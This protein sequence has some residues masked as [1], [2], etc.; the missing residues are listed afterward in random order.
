MR[1]QPGMARSTGAPAPS[2]PPNRIARPGRWAMACA[3]LSAAIAFCGA[4]AQ[5]AP[6]SATPQ[7]FRIERADPALD[8]LIAPDAT[9]RT[10][11]SGFGFADGPVWVRGHGGVPGHLLVSS[12]IGNVVYKVSPA[13]EVSVA[14]DTA[15]YSGSDFAHDGKLASFARLHLILIGPNCT[16]IDHQGRLIWCAGQDRALKRLEPDGTRT[17]LA[18]KADGKRFNGPNDV[19]I[20]ANGAI[21]FTDSDVGL[22]GGINGGL[23]QMPNAVWMWKDGKVTQVVSRDELGSE[24]NGIALSPDDKYLYL[25]AGTMSA[26]PKIMRY[27][28]KADGSVG[29]GTLFTQGP[30][31]GDGMK[32]DAKGNLY[33]TGPMPG[34][35]RIT[36]PTGKLLGLLHMPTVGNREPTKLI[37]ASA[38]AFGGDDAKTLY[39][40]AC[41]DVYAIDLKSPGLLEGPA[42]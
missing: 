40:T 17:V 4:D 32:T 21:Y 10:I 35:V 31:I 38:M 23:A 6:P 12:I 34:I 7:P 37:C 19:A 18:D 3:M 41:D 14:L 5:P 29:P 11:A 16:G 33:S 8:A 2:D 28:V 39:I 9:L 24:P 36:D 25:S 42:R 27:P 1:E 15:G 22:R 30:G 26:T 13:G 20:A